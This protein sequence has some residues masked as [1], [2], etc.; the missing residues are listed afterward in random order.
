MRCFTLI[1]LLWLIPS[2]ILAAQKEIISAC[3]GTWEPYT[4]EKNP[5]ERLAE[6]IVARAFKIEGYVLEISYQPWARCKAS[7]KIGEYDISFPWP[8]SEDKQLDFIFNKVPIIRGKEVFFFKVGSKFDWDKSSDLKSFRIGATV[9]FTHAEYLKK[10]KISYTPAK[11]ELSSFKML[12]SGR[13][14]AYPSN[15]IVA[16]RLIE[17]H[18]SN[19]EAESL[20]AHS[21]PLFIIDNFAILPKVNGERSKEIA[22]ILDVGLEKLQ[23]LGIIESILQTDSK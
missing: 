23:A 19:E 10:Y 12:L 9:G 3:I 20:M 17:R 11:N 22:A 6:E 5:N 8:L 16:K 14:D 13:V 1:I 2:S 21:K 15:S 7:V 18:F 4:S